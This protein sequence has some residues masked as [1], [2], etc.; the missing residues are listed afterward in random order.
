MPADFYIDVIDGDDANDG[1]SEGNAKQTWSALRTAAAAASYNFYIKSTQ[2][3]PLVTD[4]NALATSYETH[5]YPWSGNSRWYLQAWEELDGTWTNESGNIWSHANGQSNANATIFESTDTADVLGATT[6]LVA[7]EGASFAAVSGSM[8]AGTCYADASKIYVHATDSGDPNSNGETYFATRSNMGGTGASVIELDHVGSVNGLF[9]WGTAWMD[10]TNHSNT[11]ISGTGYIVKLNGV[12]G[13]GAQSTSDTECYY[14]SKHCAGITQSSGSNTFTISNLTVGRGPYYVGTGAHTPWVVYSDG[15][16]LNSTFAGSNITVESDKYAPGSAGGSEHDDNFISSY[17]HNVG[18]AEDN[19]SSFT[20]TDCD[21]GTDGNMDFANDYA[22][23]AGD[24]TV[25]TGVEVGGGTIWRGKMTGSTSS[26]TSKILKEAVV[27]SY[28]A[29]VDVVIENTLIKPTGT[30][31]N[32]SPYRYRYGAPFTIQNCV[33]DF[34]AIAV[35]PTAFFRALWFK[36]NT[37]ATTINFTNNLVICKSGVPMGIFKDLNVAN[38]TISTWDY[39]V[40]VL[41]SGT[42]AI[43]KNYNDG[44]TTADRTLADMQTLGFDANSQVVTAAQVDADYKPLAGAS[45]VGA[46][47]DGGNIGIVQ[48]AG[49]SLLQRHHYFLGLGAGIGLS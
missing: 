23:R 43:L 27:P 37:V 48:Q 47:S 11:S 30:P 18:A 46:A 21:F 14:G 44:T 5:F 45:I 7:I 31:T 9:G 29:G 20:Y 36:H 28:A 6:G 10:H 22:D 24:G 26:V 41:A 33:I 38:D 13:G 25:L 15:G 19:F 40:Y 4:N 42:E 12:T 2:A 39:N 17:H 8:T 34:T 49:G 1:L 32:V 35:D 3:Q 16:D